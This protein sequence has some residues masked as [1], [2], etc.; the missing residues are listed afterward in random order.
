MRWRARRLAEAG[1]GTDLWL[2]FRLHCVAKG[3]SRWK[4]NPIQES[5]T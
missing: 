4:S 5:S 1:A 2:L 3:S